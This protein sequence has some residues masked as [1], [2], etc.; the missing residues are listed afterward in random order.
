M[1]GSFD[2]TNC[3]T[4]DGHGWTSSQPARFQIPDGAALLPIHRAALARW[5]I[6]WPP[7]TRRRPEMHMRHQSESP[8]TWVISEAGE[9]MSRMAGQISG[10]ASG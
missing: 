3:G 6:G 5:A 4:D 10:K 1:G 7:R 2:T 9:V 8:G